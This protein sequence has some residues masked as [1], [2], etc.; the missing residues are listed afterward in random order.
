[1][2]QGDSTHVKIRNT[3]RSRVPT[4][5][6]LPAQHDIYKTFLFLLVSRDAKDLKRRKSTLSVHLG[7]VQ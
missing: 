2:R 1:M 6:F 4:T 3:A 7:L 5:P